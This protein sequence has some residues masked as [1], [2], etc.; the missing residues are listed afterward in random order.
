MESPWSSDYLAT[1][2][3]SEVKLTLHNANFHYE[4]LYMQS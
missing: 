1:T 4:N 3:F 2:S